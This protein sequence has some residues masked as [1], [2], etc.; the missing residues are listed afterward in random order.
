MSEAGEDGEPWGLAR[1]EAELAK[2]GYVAT[3]WH[4][5]DIRELRPD[6]EAQQA[7]DVLASIRVCN[8]FREQII[9]WYAEQLY[10]V[11]PEP[12][13]YYEA[14]VEDT[15]RREENP[16]TPSPAMDYDDPF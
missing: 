2:L 1:I 13:G 10:P 9:E 5:D 15:R 6:L 4:I 3:I 7:K 14:M 11:P 8:E 12:E 16:R